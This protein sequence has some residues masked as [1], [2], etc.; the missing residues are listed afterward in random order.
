MRSAV[1]RLRAAK[2]DDAARERVA[3]GTLRALL[4]AA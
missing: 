4:E 1:E 3:G 2:L